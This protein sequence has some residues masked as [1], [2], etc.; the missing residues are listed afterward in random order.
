MRIICVI[1]G[2]VL[3]LSSC[4][5]GPFFE[6]NSIIPSQEWE[7]AFQPEFQFEVQDTNALYDVF[8][9]IRH[10]PYYR[11]T[12][13]FLSTSELRPDSTEIIDSVRGI[14]L[15]DPEGKWLGKSTGH[16]Y[17]Q[18]VIWGANY[19]FLDTGIYTLRIRHQ[20]DDPVLIGIN[21]IGFKIVKK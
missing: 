5:T 12:D 2:F 21:D 19:R 15:A 4:Q 18:T 7:K 13:L 17:E 8:L 16:L 1:I 10:S 6:K 20:M 14:S 9:N 3:L 11:Y